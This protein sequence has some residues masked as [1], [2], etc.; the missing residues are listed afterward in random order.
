MS[1]L[2][3]ASGAFSPQ[4]TLRLVC[5]PRGVVGC[6]AQTSTETAAATVDAPRPG[7]R[8]GRFI[9]RGVLGEGGMSVVYDAF[10]P[11]LERDV[12]LKRV[13]QRAPGERGGPGDLVA[14]AR[15]LARLN[16]PNVVTIYD[17]V[18]H[19]AGHFLAL[20]KIDGT[21]LREWLGAGRRTPCEILDV[22]AG[23]AL[24]LGAAHAA[25]V[26]HRD[27][28]PDN[29]LVGRDGRVRL[30]D[31]GLAMTVSTRAP[32]AAAGTPRYAAPEQTFGA[33]P[34]PR[35][36]Q[37]SFAVAL[38]EALPME[39]LPC[40]VRAVIFRALDP[41]CDDRFP[42][43]AAFSAALARARQARIRWS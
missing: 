18:S 29:V 4:P 5:E 35:S 14:E 42:S 28:K 15:A 30:T 38:A 16:H 39:R 7:D 11:E 27:F 9:V 10:D 32:V 8:L 43:M 33:R 40:A 36:D 3:P 34:D 24:G 13:K 20:E 17:V 23:A 2:F 21:T 12:A 31:F 19:V 37:Y 6:P 22:F 41:R 1:C 26:V 25:G